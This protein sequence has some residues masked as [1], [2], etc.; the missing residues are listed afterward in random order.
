[1]SK[2]VI[3]LRPDCKVIQE[4][5]ESDGQVSIGAK[6]IEYLEKLNA[7]Y[8]NEHFGD[9]QG[10]AYQR[11]LEDGKKAFDLLESERNSEY[12]RGLNEG[13]GIGYKDGVNDGQHEA[14]KAARKIVLSPDEE[15]ISA[16][17]LIAIFG[18][19]SAY[20][21]F[22]NYTASEAI[23]K[24]KAYEEKQKTDNCIEIGD[25]VEWDGD[26]YIVTY[27]NTNMGVIQDYD[28][29]SRYGSVVDH[30]KRC[31]FVKTGRHF[32]IAKILEEM[33]E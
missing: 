31:S 7:D 9:L 11:G 19:G 30:V 17:D 2:Y 21:V 3:D 28:L 14:W 5:C 8:I 24:L 23:A 1:M 6:S 20:N 16:L 13:N 27:R 18:K 29:M 12:Q 32:D 33:K 4:I 15:G 26:K 10:T 25:E 22:K